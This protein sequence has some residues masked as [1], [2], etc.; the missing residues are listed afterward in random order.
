MRH[1][2]REELDADGIGKTMLQ[3]RFVVS[4]LRTIVDLQC[5]PKTLFRMISIQSFHFQSSGL[6]EL[7]IGLFMTFPGTSRSLLAY[8][9]GPNR[10]HRPRRSLLLV[11]A[12]S[13]LMHCRPTIAACWIGGNISFAGA[14]TALQPGSFGHCGGW[15][16]TV[17]TTPD[18]MFRKRN[19][20]RI[21]MWE[22]GLLW[23]YFPTAA[24]AHYGFSNLTVYPTAPTLCNAQTPLQRREVPDVVNA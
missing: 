12:V 7:I 2:T 3:F 11:P 22:T 17:S 15:G 20:S 6:F 14:S 19:G 16:L 4:I 21:S 24:C 13:L 9:V 8:R 5:R 10:M 18:Q 23:A 1:S